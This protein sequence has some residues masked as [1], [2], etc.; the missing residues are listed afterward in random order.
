MMMNPCDPVHP[1]VAA[2]LLG[3][4]VDDVYERIRRGEL[5]VRSI[6]GQW[7]VTLDGLIRRDEIIQP[8]EATPAQQIDYREELDQIQ[9]QIQSLEAVIRDVLALQTP[10]APVQ[11]PAQSAPAQRLVETTPK[12]RNWQGLVVLGVIVALALAGS[13]VQTSS[14]QRSDDLT[15]VL[16]FVAGIVTGSIASWLALD[17]PATRTS[18]DSRRAQQIGTTPRTSDRDS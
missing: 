5:A 12:G 8:V 4:S 14:A 15:V 11:A 13:M 9:A 6:D 17:R 7:M 1:N 3:V 16:I 18:S 10:V 2:D